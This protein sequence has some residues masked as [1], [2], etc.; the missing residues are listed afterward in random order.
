ML[1]G[2]LYPDQ[3]LVKTYAP[4]KNSFVQ[5]RLLSL[6]AAQHVFLRMVNNSPHPHQ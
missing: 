6:S 4:I 1:R 2:T 5:N 3:E